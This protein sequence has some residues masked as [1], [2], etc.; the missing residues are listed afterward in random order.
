MSL[1][2]FQLVSLMAWL[3][4]TLNEVEF[5]RLDPV[6]SRYSSSDVISP[7]EAMIATG[8][9]GAMSRYLPSLSVMDTS[10]GIRDSS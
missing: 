7:L 3:S 1:V 8:P 10:W 6:W 5:R 2:M 9:K 4:V